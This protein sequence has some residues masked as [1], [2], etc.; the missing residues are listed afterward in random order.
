MDTERSQI[1]SAEGAEE[2]EESLGCL[3]MV[4]A[5]PILRRVWDTPEEDE[6]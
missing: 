4:G 6:A 2:Q 5:M 1:E 3:T